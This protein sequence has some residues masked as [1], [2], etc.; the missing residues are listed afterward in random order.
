MARYRI[1][2]DGKEWRMIPMPIFI[3]RNSSIWAEY[4]YPKWVEF[5]ACFGII[6]ASIGLLWMLMALIVSII[7]D[8][9]IDITERPHSFSLALALFGIGI[10][11]ISMVLMLIT[12]QSVTE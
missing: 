10:S 11:I 5:I 7:T 4:V 3:P 2:A 8:D 12:G 1:R 6:A 9:F